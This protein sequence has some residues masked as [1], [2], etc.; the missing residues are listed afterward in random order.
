MEPAGDHRQVNWKK[1]ELILED[2]DRMWGSSI[3]KI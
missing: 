3:K 2:E 1:K